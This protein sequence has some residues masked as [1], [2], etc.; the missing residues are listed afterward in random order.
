MTIL[1]TM[2][3]FVPVYLQNINICLSHVPTP[4]GR[5]EKEA[6]RVCG[7]MAPPLYAGSGRVCVCACVY[8][9]KVARVD[10]LAG[11]GCSCVL[12]DGLRLC[13]HVFNLYVWGG[14]VGVMLSM[15]LCGVWMVCVCGCVYVRPW[16]WCCC[17]GGK[18]NRKTNRKSCQKQ[19]G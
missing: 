13:G 15:C 11:G 3:Q 19:I 4:R 16:W 8:A 14:C 12:V 18:T 1:S 6:G 9:L 5:R 7:G 10:G 2:R 17:V